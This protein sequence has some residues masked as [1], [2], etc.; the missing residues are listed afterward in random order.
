LGGFDQVPER[1]RAELAPHGA[2]RLNTVVTGVTWRPGGGVE[3]HCRSSAGPAL[4]PVRGR[5]VVVAVP[6]GVLQAG[7]GEPGT[8]RFDPPLREKREAA[9]RL[10][11]G[12]VVKVVFHFRSQ[13]WEERLH[14]GDDG[15][16]SP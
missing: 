10:A 12:D 3:V 11:M 7:E 4:E 9:R 6:L 13:L 16:G 2:V 8:T 5:Y 15:E 14:F 1:L